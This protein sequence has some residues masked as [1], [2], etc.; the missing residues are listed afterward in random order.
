VKEVLENVKEDEY[1]VDVSRFKSTE[2]L[3]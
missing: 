3:E 2:E 1:L